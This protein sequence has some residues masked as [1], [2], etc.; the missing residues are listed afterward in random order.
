MYSDNLFYSR[1]IGRYPH[2][3]PVT[4]DGEYVKMPESTTILGA[5]KL[6]GKTKNGLSIGILESVTNNEN[7]IIDNNGQRRKE[8]VEPLTS[9]FTGRVQQDIKK[10]ETVIGGLVTAVNRRYNKSCP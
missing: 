7:A 1:R 3:Y 10:G 4:S 5:A 2:N 6:S 9:Y 8:N